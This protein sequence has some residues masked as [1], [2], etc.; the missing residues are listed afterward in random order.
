VDERRKREK[1]GK[2]KGKGKG[3]EKEGK[4]ERS[5]AYFSKMSEI[6]EAYKRRPSGN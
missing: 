5:G 6:T 2:R 1:E 3:K 4:E